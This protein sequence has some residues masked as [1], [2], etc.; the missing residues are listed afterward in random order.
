MSSSDTSTFDFTP[1]LEAEAREDFESALEC[2]NQAV[3]DALS[4]QQQSEALF[5]RGSL[6]FRLGEYRHALNDLNNSVKQ[7][8]EDC[9]YLWEALMNQG[10][11]KAL[12]GDLPGAEGALLKAIELSPGSGIA[13]LNMAGV[14]VRMGDK[15]GA[16]LCLNIA[17]KALEQQD[18]P[19]G[20]E[21]AKDLLGQISNA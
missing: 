8:H 21:A 20:V 15:Q 17:M 3:S 5:H 1:A 7:A 2:Y 13:Y 6:Y 10:M 9:E 19:A 4:P 11:S 16:V 18:D 14:K 12:M